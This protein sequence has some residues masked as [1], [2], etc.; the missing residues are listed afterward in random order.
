MDAEIR[1][2]DGITTVGIGESNHWVTMDGPEIH[3][4]RAGAN[5][6]MEL[7]L[8]AQ[9]GCTAMDV[10]SILTKMHQPYTDMTVRVNGTQG[11]EHPRVFTSIKITY[12]VTGKVDPAKLEKAIVL[13]LEKYCPI[14]AMLGKACSIEWDYEIVND[15]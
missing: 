12:I 11:Q 7:L 13:S 4:G 14:S 6:P 8:I 15:V 5:K 1:L 2:V 9:G 3:K 10:L